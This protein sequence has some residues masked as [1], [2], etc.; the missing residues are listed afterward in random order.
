[1]QALLIWT[2]LPVFVLGVVLFFIAE[3][4]LAAEAAF[5]VVRGAGLVLC[6]LGAVQTM[7]LSFLATS[8]GLAP[9]AKSWRLCASWQFATIAGL[10]LYLAYRT[11][12]GGAAVPETWQQKVL[13]AAWLLAIVLSFA[14]GAGL[15]WAR[16]DNG[17]G[18]FAEPARVARSGLSWLLVGML[19][20][21]ITSVN[22]VAAQKDIVR[23]WSYLKVTSPSPST[24]A[25]I[26][27]LTDDLQI[28]VFYPNGN[29]VLTFVKQ[30]VEQIAAAEPRIK[31]SYFDQ[32]LNP[33]KAEQFK[34]ARNGQIILELGQKRSRIEPGLTL[35]KAR[36]TLRNFDQEFQKAFFEITAEKKSIYFTRGHGE[37]SWVGDNS[38]DALTSL[39]LL[40]AVLRQQSYSLKAFG[41]AEGSATAVPDDAA[42]VI[43]AGPTQ[44]FQAEEAETLKAY[45]ERGGNLLVFFDL[46]K[47][48]DDLASAAP[49]DKDPLRQFIETVGITFNDLPLANDKNYVSAT[50]SPAD[51]WFI[52]SNI[53]TSHESV[54]SLARNDERIAV[55]IYQGG[56]L[57]LKRES[58]DWKVTESVRSLA[59]SFV[60]N[61]RDF[62]LS[63]SEKRNSYV[64]GAV[65]EPKVP[66]VDPKS[67][68]PGGRI[69]AVAD[70]SLLSDALL[71]NPGNFVFV[72]DTIK[73]LVGDVDRTGQVASEEDVK[74][75]HTRKE[76]V[77]YFHATV[78]VVPLLVLAAGYF[79]TRRRRDGEGSDS[80][81]TKQEKTDAT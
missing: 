66:K 18:Q 47:S 4:Y 65:A 80:E 8:E 46:P 9:E 55:L 44:S 1:M 69:I 25:S 41:I 53:F 16:R 15:E 52:F 71:R 62:Q 12:L 31:I 17:R 32:E 75:R 34:A 40:E 38:D 78:A 29:D 76:D 30:Y 11:V 6:V 48:K 73:W 36:K 2:R 61:D 24:L 19:L 49:T 72:S 54:A 56:H 10:G 20:A 43:V 21:V 68:K 79:A 45:V 67:K 27:S 59:D 3:R 28:A 14:A 63:G 35:A 58:A 81:Q 13:L 74:I 57:T 70:A 37:L 23:D 50:R 51:A 60:D 77:I 22:Y 26:K 42:A 33:V 64:L 5:A 7:L 39:A